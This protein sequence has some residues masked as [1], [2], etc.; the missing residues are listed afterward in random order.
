M[1]M[2]RKEVEKIKQMYPKGTKIELGYMDDF[3]APP[4]GTVGEVTHV[5]DIGQIHVIWENGS[6]LALNTDVDSFHKI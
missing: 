4:S 6:T 2:N 1:F 3:Q 5:D